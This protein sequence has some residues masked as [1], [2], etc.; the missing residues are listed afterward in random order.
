V[1]DRVWFGVE[2]GL[3][4]GA[5]VEQIERDRPGPERPYTFGVSRRSGGADYLLPSTDQLRNEPSADRTARAYNEDS[6]VALL[7][8]VVH[9]APTTT[10]S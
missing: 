2:H 1:D 5:C 9:P 6:H 4:H 7:L 8:V 10:T 3:A